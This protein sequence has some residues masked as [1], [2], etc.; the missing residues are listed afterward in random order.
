M[1]SDDKWMLGRLNQVVASVNESLEDFRFHDAVHNLYEFVWGEFCDWYIE[2]SKDT[3]FS[4][5]ISDKRDRALGLFDYAMFIILKLL[6]PFMPFVTE[7][8]SHQLGYLK[9]DES[10]M[11]AKFPEAL[12]A[13]DLARLGISEELIRKVVAKFAIISAGRN[14][15]ASCN[16]APSLKIKYF[17]RPVDKATE[18]F[19]EEQRPAIELLLRAES[20]VID[21]DFAAAGPAPSIVTDAGTIFMPLEGLVDIQAE[22]AKLQKQKIELEGW[23]AG[24]KAKLSN[25]RF[26]SKAPPKV[27]EEAKKILSENEGKLIRVEEMLASLGK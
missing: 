22:L 25:E 16:I 2:V 15:R 8:I 20:L 17:I 6:H 3:F 18:I 24:S 1:S 12:P 26:V 11:L 4:K 7:E 27:I 21:A 9:E 14:L 23:I 10:I 13:A 19:L 5:E